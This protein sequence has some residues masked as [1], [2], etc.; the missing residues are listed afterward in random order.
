MA[1]VAHDEMFHHH[2]NNV[3]AK[4]MGYHNT[5]IKMFTT[6]NFGWRKWDSVSISNIVLQMHESVDS[7]T[8]ILLCVLFRVPYRLS[9]DCGFV[10][11][12]MFSL[13]PMHPLVTPF[14]LYYFLFCSP[15]WRRNLLY[16]Y[17]PSHDAGGIRWP[18]FAD[19]LVSGMIVAQSFLTIKLMLHNLYGPA[20]LA[21]LSIFPII[22]HRKRISD[23]Y[24][25]AYMDAAL[26]QTSQVDGWESTATTSE[27][28]RE[29]FRRF[30][31]DAHKA[32]YVPICLAVGHKS[33]SLTYEPAVVIP[34]ESD[35][36]QSKSKNDD[37][38]VSGPDF[39]NSVQRGAYWRRVSVRR[40]I[41]ESK[42]L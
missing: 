1:Q 2:T 3:Y 6:S 29:K 11:F 18:F 35:I 17:R 10:F 16:L 25:D 5:S 39:R 21:V 14:P 41:V 33:D 38:L 42:D 30:L 37:D 27:V 31:V 34:L 9:I 12:I 8:N 23:D 20:L 28:K 40:K 4:F 36:E 22:L 19:M 15:L 24:Y 32:A 13:T 7:L 26:L